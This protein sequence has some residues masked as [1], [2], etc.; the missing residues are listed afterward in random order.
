MRAQTRF[1]MAITALASATPCIASPAPQL[2]ETSFAALPQPLALP[3]NEAANAHR[4]IAAARTFGFLRDEPI[5][6]WCWSTSAV[7]PKT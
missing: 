2:A 4:E 1:W 6:R 7:T 5:M 3:Y